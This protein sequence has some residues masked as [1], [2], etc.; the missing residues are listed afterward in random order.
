MM[1][2]QL[3]TSHFESANLELG[4][5]HNGA[6]NARFACIMLH[7]LASNATRWREFMLSSTLGHHFKLIAMDLRGHGHSMTWARYTR[8]DW[9]ADLHTLMRQENK[10][11]F[12]AGHSLG[13]QIALDYASQFS[14]DVTSKLC[15]L[16]LIDP[17]F[18]QALDGAL[19]KVGRF[20]GVV[21]LFGSL[22]RCCYAIGLRKKHYP[23]RNL[24]TLDQQTREF[25]QANP[26]KTI[27]DLYMN[28]F[29]DL[30]FLPLAN[31]LQ[32]LY[33]VTRPLSALKQIQVPVLVLLS[34]GASTSVVDK[35]RQILQ[36]IANLE[37]KT[38][39]ADHWPLTEKPAEVREAIDEWC[40]RIAGL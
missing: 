6:I 24:Q 38:I 9:I 23:Y 20:R 4:I 8:Q 35:N 10:L 27:A 16:V 33:E 31:Y 5:T 17:V 21:K 22:V 30:A 40:L 28:P 18:P 26:D 39:H 15:G 3:Q 32:D 7:G 29:S 19:K 36:A 34:E 12:L 13:A 14:N 11:T 37:I 25:L 1:H 2:P